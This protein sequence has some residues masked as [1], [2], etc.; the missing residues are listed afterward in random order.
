MEKRERVDGKERE[1]GE[2]RAESGWKREACKWGRVSG[3]GGL[4]PA[5]A[6]GA[7]PQRWER[8]VGR[9]PHAAGVGAALRRLDCWE[10]RRKGARLPGCQAAP[11]LLPG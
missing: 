9:R 4:A 1:S 11:R 8:P 10:K 5:R 6:K 7:L 3:A 2:R